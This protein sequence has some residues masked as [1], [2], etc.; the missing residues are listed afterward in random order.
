MI[1]VKYDGREEGTKLYFHRPLCSL[2]SFVVQ[3]L[4][5]SYYITVIFLPCLSQS[6][7]LTAPSHQK[8][9]SILARFS[10]RDGVG[11]NTTEAARLSLI[12]HLDP[13]DEHATCPRCSDSAP[14]RRK[15]SQHA[16]ALRSHDQESQSCEQLCHLG[17]MPVIS[18]PALL[19]VATVRSILIQDMSL[20]APR[21]DTHLPKRLYV[22]EGWETCKSLFLL[23]GRG[24]KE[25]HLLVGD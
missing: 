22:I 7:H 25:E 14:E 8:H 11:I 2:F 15:A 24:L 18:A 9:R 1:T 5:L 20:K 4:L 3:T 23:S 19:L 12:Y 10:L 21:K 16:D 17:T 13:T 6:T